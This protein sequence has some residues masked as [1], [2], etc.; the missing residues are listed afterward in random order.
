[1]TSA[2]H[3]SFTYSLTYLLVVNESSSVVLTTL[4]LCFF[5]FCAGVGS[6]RQQGAIRLLFFGRL[7]V[8]KRKSSI[9]AAAVASERQI[10]DGKENL[11]EE[12]NSELKC[13]RA[14]ARG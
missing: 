10:T 11:R 13:C 8:V 12:T 3:K 2:L 6:N 7:R 5:L 1:M 9:K 4:K 14:Y